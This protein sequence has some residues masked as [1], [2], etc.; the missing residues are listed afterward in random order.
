MRAL[1]GI[2]LCVLL[3]QTQVFALS[4]GPDYN[5]GGS[6]SI[7]NIIGT[8]G[9]VMVEESSFGSFGLAGTGTTIGGDGGGGSIAIYA[10]QIAASG[11]STGNVIIFTNGN[12]Y[13]G[14]I[15]GIGDTSGKSSTFKG[16]VEATFDYNYQLPQTETITKDGETTTKTTFVTKTATVVSN[17][18]MDTIIEPVRN[19]PVTSV[20]MSGSATLLV[21]NFLSP[22]LTVVY[23]VSGYR[24]IAG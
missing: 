24:Q 2:L 16:I 6:G 10:V 22:S 18:T 5:R 14:T 15:S 4:G 19:G 11:I 21:G 23:S 7:A 12:V 13:P 9:G 8:Y 20:L 17:G 3:L 1:L